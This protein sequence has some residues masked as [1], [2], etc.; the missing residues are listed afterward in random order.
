[1]GKLKLHYTKLSLGRENLIKLD[2]MENKR[3]LSQNNG[4]NGL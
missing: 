4:A 3:E 2:M 1:M